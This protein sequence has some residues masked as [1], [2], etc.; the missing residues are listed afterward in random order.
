MRTIQRAIFALLAA[1]LMSAL[2][3]GTTSTSASALSTAKKDKVIKKAASLKGTPYR[4]GGTSTRGFD[5]SGYTQYV[6]KKA[7]KKKLPRVADA[8]G[9]AGKA[10]KKS[11]KHR[12][13]LIVFTRGG[14][15]YH[16]GIY[17]GKN[18]IWHAS[19]PGQPVKKERIWTSGYKVRRL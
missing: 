4:W 18:K 3:I 11:R 7:L 6:Y 14:R 10:V 5:C 12:G 13:D 2:V 1:V 17:A 16:V 19:R 15:G 9:R 8:Q